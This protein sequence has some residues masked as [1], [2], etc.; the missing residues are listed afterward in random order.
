MRG[1]CMFHNT[2]FDRK[3]WNVPKWQLSATPLA[4]QCEQIYLHAKDET[5]EYVPT[6]DG[7]AWELRLCEPCRPHMQREQI[8]AEDTQLDDAFMKERTDRYLAGDDD[9]SD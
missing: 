1:G 2:R 4:L 5:V 6:Y 8:A 9:D 3:H 7:N